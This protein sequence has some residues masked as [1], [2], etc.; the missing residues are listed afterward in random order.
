MQLI[1]IGANTTNKQ[2]THKPTPM[3]Y[4]FVARKLL[5][6][7]VHPKTQTH[8]RSNMSLIVMQHYTPH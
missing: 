5:K 3:N 7:K 2:I 8:A 1:Q 6:T 4:L